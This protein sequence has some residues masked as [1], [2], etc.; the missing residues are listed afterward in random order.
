M[1]TISIVSTGSISKTRA[2]ASVANITM[3]C[4]VGLV[5]SFCLI[6]FGVDIG[7]AWL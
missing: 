5:T 6:A 2:D 1:T 3:L 4:C 7:A